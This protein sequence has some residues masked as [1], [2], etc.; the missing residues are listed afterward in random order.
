[1]HFFLKL[2]RSATD[3]GVGW[4]TWVQVKNQGGTTLKAQLYCFRAQNMARGGCAAER[5][6]E[7]TSQRVADEASE[8]D[9]QQRIF[10]QFVR[11]VQRRLRRCRR[12]ATSR[13]VAWPIQPPQRDRRCGR[14][15]AQH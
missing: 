2:L 9:P 5:R 11:L 15:D 7:P 3:D 13:A 6:R 8:R 1:M 14:W 4:R 12:S 10:D